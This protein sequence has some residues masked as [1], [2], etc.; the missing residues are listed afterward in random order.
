MGES[1]VKLNKPIYLG[2]A[3]LDLSKTLMYKFHY[4]YIKPK[5]GDKARLL[6]TDTDSLCYEIQTE[7]FYKDITGDVSRWFDTSNYLEDHFSGIPT[8]VNKK[9]LGMMKDEAGGKQVTEFVGLRSKL[10]A[11]TIENNENKKCKGVKK[12]VVKNSIAFVQ[13]KD[14]LFNNTIYQ[15]KFNTLRSRKHEITTECIT[16]I[17]LSA[18]DNKRHIIPNDP[19]YRTLTLGHYSLNA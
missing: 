6:F 1:T 12:K 11:Y 5:Y 14:C 4:E 9:V 2:Q 18:S 10:Y 13:Y 17:A 8:G 7:D 15:A 3:I 19:E 16:K